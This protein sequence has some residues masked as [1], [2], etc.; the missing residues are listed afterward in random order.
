[1]IADGGAVVEAGAS[2]GAQ[3]QGEG[4]GHHH[5]PDPAHDHHRGGIDIGAVAG[6][7]EADENAARHRGTRKAIN[8]DVLRVLNDLCHMSLFPC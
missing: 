7:I 3:A 1:M 2:A 6:M 8:G 5:D 4:E